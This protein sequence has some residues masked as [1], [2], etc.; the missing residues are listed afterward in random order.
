MGKIYDIERGNIFRGGIGRNL[1]Y[2]G[3]ERYIGYIVVSILPLRNHSKLVEIIGYNSV[4]T[5]VKLF[6]HRI[7]E[8]GLKVESAQGIVFVQL[9]SITS[10]ESN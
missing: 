6:Y 9:V 1:F 7:V 3:T 8:R 5:L 2:G 10:V 4:D